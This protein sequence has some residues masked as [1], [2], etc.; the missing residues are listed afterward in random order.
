DQDLVQNI[1]SHWS[2]LI[3]IS[4]PSEFHSA[5][6]GFTAIYP[7]YFIAYTYLPNSQS[8]LPTVVKMITL[9]FQ[10][11]HRQIKSEFHQK[12]LLLCKTFT[13]FSHC[14]MGRSPAFL[15]EQPIID[16]EI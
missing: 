1:L 15:S 7:R 13:Q 10:E 2:N 11:Q 4:T 5:Y 3:N 16:V 8:S 12:T 9:F 6:S 14:V